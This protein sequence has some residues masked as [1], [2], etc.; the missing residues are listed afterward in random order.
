MR[1]SFGLALL[2]SALVAGVVWAVAFW[3]PA[4]HD[5]QDKAWQQAGQR[6]LAQVSLP[7]SF[8][9]HDDGSARRI[10]I[11]STT[12]ALLCYRTAAD[13]RS[14]IA[15]LRAAL[16]PLTTGTARST[17][18]ADAPLRGSPVSCTMRV[19]VHGSAL[20]A[21]LFPLLDRHAFAGTWSS[22]GTEVEI[23]VAER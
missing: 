15:P 10:R 18:E 17:C 8:R 3:L 6:A 21:E 11:C 22:T 23:H 12:P 16:A 1:R 5:R 7:A 13:P 4:W 9:A 2:A 20:V 19:P 14:A